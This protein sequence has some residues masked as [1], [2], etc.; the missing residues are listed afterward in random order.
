MTALLLSALSHTGFCQSRVL[1]NQ[2]DERLTEL[3]KIC[4]QA[5]RRNDFRTMQ[6]TLDAR[7]TIMKS[8]VDSASYAYHSHIA[9]YFKDSGSMHYCLADIDGTSIDEARLN[10]IR[11]LEIYENVLK[12]PHGA[13]VIRTELAQMHY[14][15]EEYGEALKYLQSNR[16]HYYES[17]LESMEL[18]TWSEEALCKARLGR[19][20]ESLRDIDSVITYLPKTT[21]R[22]EFLRKK[23]K[24]LALKAEADNV[25]AHDAVPYFSEYFKHQTDSLTSAFSSMSPQQR[26]SYWLRMRPFIRD[27]YRLEDAAAGLLYDAALFNKN[28]LFQFSGMT[29]PEPVPCWKDIQK[30]LDTNECAIEFLHY[31]KGGQ[32]HLGA[33]VLKSEGEPIFRHVIK[34]EELMSFRLDNEIPVRTALNKEVPSYKDALYSCVRLKNAIWNNGLRK[35]VGSMKKI[36]F[37]ADGIIH[38]M[39]IEYMF[40]A[41]KE[42]QLIR[43]SSTRE[44]LK[45]PAMDGSGMLICGGPDYFATSADA[46][47]TGNDSLAYEIL[48]RNGAFFRPLKGALQEAKEIHSIRNIRQDTLV[49]G[50][51]ASESRIRDLI[52][53]YP[54]ITIATHGYFGGED[55]RTGTDLKT[56]ETD[57]MLSSSA[58]ILAG[59][60]RNISDPAFDSR[61]MDGIL[62]ARELSEMNLSNIS[63]ITLS[64]CQSGLGRITADGIFGLQRGL[65]NAG[66]RSMIVSLWDVDDEA[67]K[68]FMVNFNK[69]LKEGM[70]VGDAFACARDSMDEEIIFTTKEFDAGTLSESDSET[71]TKKSFSKPRYKNAFILLDNLL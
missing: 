58:L 57:R 45:E 53:H 59:A 71:T 43:L 65:K 42:P 11:S 39:A 9:L 32:M 14:Q 68:H 33:V 8:Y 37:S 27:C 31:E 50:G 21:G 17:G 4:E 12:D 15:A 69:A 62:S 36:Y 64:A 10:Y 55:H 48:S 20:E 51:A 5:Y 60:Q 18:Q 61:L 44:L 26:E 35:E 24:V 22:Q 41:A 63:L 54:I 47:S 1:T 23:G 34:T 6:E 16:R 7:K 29:H 19:F 67:T 25:E 38:K 66:V 52:R 49:T 56:W 2:E 40:P 30:R 3:H 70:T 13:A 46:D 28:I